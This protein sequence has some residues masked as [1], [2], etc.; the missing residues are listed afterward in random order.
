MRRQKDLKH[1]FVGQY[2][3]NVAE[4]TYVYVCRGKDGKIMCRCES[5]EDA[6][7]IAG[8]LDAHDREEVKS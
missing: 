2:Q 8:L 3:F 7:L 6:E 5:E 4:V 1:K